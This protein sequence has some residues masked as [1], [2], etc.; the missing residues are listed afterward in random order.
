MYGINY[1]QCVHARGP[2]KCYITPM[3]VGGG[4]IFSGKSVTKV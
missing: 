1:Q 3:G 4:V 2:F